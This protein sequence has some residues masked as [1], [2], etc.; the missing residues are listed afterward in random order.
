MEGWRFQSNSKKNLNYKIVTTYKGKIGPVVINQDLSV[1][2]Y[3]VR[4]EW[5]RGKKKK[6]TIQQPVRVGAQRGLWP[7]A[8]DG[9]TVREDKEMKRENSGLSGFRVTSQ[10]QVNGCVFNLIWDTQQWQMWV[11]VKESVIVWRLIQKWHSTM[12]THTHS[13][14]AHT[15]EVFVMGRPLKTPGSVFRFTLLAWTQLSSVQIVQV[16]QWVIIQKI[17]RSLTHSFNCNFLK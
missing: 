9:V 17:R 10:R 7:R 6:I 12:C 1:L 2:S 5:L 15:V 4:C 11:W 16:L 3:L 8:R 13:H 14:T